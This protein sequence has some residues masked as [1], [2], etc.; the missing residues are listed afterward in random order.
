MRRMEWRRANR[1]AEVRG[2]LG[3]DTMCE[4]R[5]EF[6]NKGRKGNE[7]EDRSRGVP[8]IL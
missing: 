7:G 8:W 2:G 3:I 5:V 1:V 4:G 6:C